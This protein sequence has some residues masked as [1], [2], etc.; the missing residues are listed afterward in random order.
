MSAR[1]PCPVSRRMERNTGKA[2]FPRVS[3]S[4]TSC[5]ACSPRLPALCRGGKLRT[6]CL[7]PE[8][9]RTARPA[10][11]TGTQIVETWGSTR[12][13]SM[14]A[15]GHNHRD[16]Q[17]P[18]KPQP[19]SPFNHQALLPPRGHAAAA[20]RRAWREREEGAP[21][22]HPQE[23]NRHPPACHQ[24]AGRGKTPPGSVTSNRE[25]KR[26]PLK[27]VTKL[28]WGR[29]RNPYTW[30]RLGHRTR[31]DKMGVGLT[32]NTCRVHGGEAQG[33]PPRPVTG[34][35]GHRGQPPRAYLRGEGTQGPPSGPRGHGSSPL[36]PSP[37]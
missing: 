24:C 1:S 23:T 18:P 28:E 29:R 15:E 36:G 35:T 2:H 13:T 31:R 34:V 16:P 19:Q 11:P 3:R 7:H 14:Q 12:S 4:M 33:P 25:G 5:R 6:T 37:G 17:Q 20:H 30:H 32:S 27:P 21:P 9:R 8:P 22:A 26:E 10:P